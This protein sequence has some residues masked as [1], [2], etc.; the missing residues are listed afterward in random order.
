MFL[1]HHTPRLDEKGRLFLPAV[2]RDALAGGVVVTKGQEPCL[3]V[4]DA[5][6]FAKAADAVMGTPALTPEDRNFKRV[7]FSS[8]FSQVP[9]KQGRMTLP[10]ELRSYAG[11]ER[12]VV[13]VGVG[14]RLEIWD[15]G[16]WDS[17]TDQ[18]DT[19]YKAQSAEVASL[20]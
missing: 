11:L 13:V 15:A 7:F 17:G 8:A 3:Y 2:H 4:Y 18:R 19:D 5:A 14:R 16:R 20:L 12:D 1:G 10:Q 9:D 6:A